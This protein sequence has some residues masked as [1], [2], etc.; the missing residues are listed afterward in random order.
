MGVRKAF[1]QVF[2]LRAVAGDRSLARQS[3]NAP[4][5]LR[6]SAGLAPDFPTLSLDYAPRHQNLAGLY[7][8][9][10]P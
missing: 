3:P 10:G 5:P 2:G 1:W 4:L 6:D 8:P 9:N 7:G